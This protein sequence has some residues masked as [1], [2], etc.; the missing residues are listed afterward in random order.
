MEF[1]YK[2]RDKLLEENRKLYEEFRRKKNKREDSEKKGEDDIVSRKKH[3]HPNN[4]HHASSHPSRKEKSYRSISSS[5][6][7]DA[8]VDKDL[9]RVTA[10]LRDQDIRDEVRAIFGPGGGARASSPFVADIRD[11]PF[12]KGFK[13]Y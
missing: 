8:K 11:Y 4:S 13:L 6:K 2:N 10:P 12:P 9:P 5:H 7:E 3:P 1:F